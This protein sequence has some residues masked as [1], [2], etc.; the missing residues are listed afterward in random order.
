MP[1]AFHAVVR[2]W[3]ACRVGMGGYATWPDAGGVNDQAAWLVEAFGILSA[4]DA[5]FDEIDRE[6]RG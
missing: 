3:S 2:L 1:D 4:A 6:R 5:E